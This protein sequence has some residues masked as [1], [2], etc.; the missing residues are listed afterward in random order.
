M[1]DKII[2]S[3]TCG[4]HMDVKLVYSHTCGGHMDVKLVYS[5]TCGGHMDV[6]LVYSHTCG[7]HM[8]VKL[9]YS[10]TCG[11]HMD[12]KLVYERSGVFFCSFIF[13]YPSTTR[14]PPVH[15]PS[16]HILVTGG[17]WTGLCIK[18]LDVVIFCVDVHGLVPLVTNCFRQLVRG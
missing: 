12:V 11:G 2:A 8:D 1:Q 10:H 16:T 13:V 14:P 17:R 6:K 4:G 3:H 5:H 9:V 7:G 15:H 18:L